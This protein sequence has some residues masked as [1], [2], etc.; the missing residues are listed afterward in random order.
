MFQLHK[1]KLRLLK[2]RAAGAKCRWKAKEVLYLLR[3]RA[4]C[5]P[6]RH[7]KNRKVIILFYRFSCFFRKRQIRQR[8]DSAKQRTVAY[9][10]CQLSLCPDAGQNL[11]FSE[12]GGHLM[13]QLDIP[14]FCII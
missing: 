1:L 4:L 12:F 6:R 11:F 8:H 10:L 3:I 7:C 9:C 13:C 2:C 5:I 14:L